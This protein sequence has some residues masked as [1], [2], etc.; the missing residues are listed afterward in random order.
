MTRI[1]ADIDALKE[2]HEA[3]A[4]F[5]H[6][7]REVADRGDHELA[8]TR[9]SLEAKAGKWRARLDQARHELDAC[10]FR[11]A[12]AAREGHYVDCSGFARA[13]AEAEERLEHV[14][15]WQQRVEDEAAVFRGAADRF[16]GFLDADLVRTQDHVI[17]VIQ[18]LEAARDVRT[19]GS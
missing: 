19:P 8:A 4:L 15:G 5:R 16:R 14:Q 6:A 1:H 17:T 9:A 3:L 12:V 18:T 10:Q 11:A 13:V 2:L 7:E